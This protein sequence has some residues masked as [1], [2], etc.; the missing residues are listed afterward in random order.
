MKKGEIV[1]SAACVAFFGSM[2]FETLG[3]LGQGRAGEM[4]SGLWP[5]LALTVALVLSL[6]MLV[7]S[8]RKY[9]AAARK[10]APEPTS[11]DLA[12]KKRRRATVTLSIA[13]FVA[14]ILVMPWIGFILGTLLYVLAFALTLGERRRW[15]LGVSPFLVTAVIVAVFAKFIT[16][17]FPKGIGIFADFSRLFY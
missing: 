17:P 14:Y 8:I 11:E 9:R 6:L 7:G 3:L 2:L 4:G 16:I 12:E 5:F 13:A 1:F 10:D 15:V